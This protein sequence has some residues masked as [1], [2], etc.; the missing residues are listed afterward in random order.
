MCSCYTGDSMFALA[1]LLTACVTIDVPFQAAGPD[2]DAIPIHKGVR[3]ADAGGD[4]AVR[5]TVESWDPKQTAI[6]V[7]DMWDAHHCL[8]AVR[9]AEQMAP[10]MNRVLENARS[11]GVF[12]VHAPSSCMEPYK[13]HP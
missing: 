4:F 3:S 6:I 9:R 13:D 5:E 8:N 2:V 1:T 12:I 10:R 7:C 11:R